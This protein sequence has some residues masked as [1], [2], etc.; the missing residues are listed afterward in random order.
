MVE[1]FAQCQGDVDQADE[2]GH[3]ASGRPAFTQ[4]ADKHLA[5][6]AGLIDPDQF[7]LITKPSIGYLVLRGTAG[8]GKTT[9]ALHRIAFLAYEN[10]AID[11]QETMVVVFS[12]ALRD[13]VS[14]VLPA[15]QV[16]RVQVKTFEEW[17]K[18]QVQRLLPRLP[19]RIREITPAIVLRTKFHPA[20]MKA[21]EQHVAR[22]PGRGDARQITDDWNSVLSDRQLIGEV[23]E[24]E[25][26]GAFS[27]VHASLLASRRRCSSS[28]TPINPSAITSIT[29]DMALA[30][31]RFSDSTSPKT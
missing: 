1:P 7:E 13:Y 21:F 14:H 27:T 9:V 15:L 8:S 17:A 12:P 22:T 5:D 6:I 24:R 30:P 3:L 23:F 20:M 4:R 11:S 28:T 18:D 26:P 19:R 29:T 10:P 2:H 16:E 25:A 31:R